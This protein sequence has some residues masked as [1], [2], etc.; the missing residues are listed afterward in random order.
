[1]SVVGT[2]I[3]FNETNEN[4]KLTSFNHPLHRLNRGSFD[5]AVN[6]L[7]A[8]SQ[9]SNENNPHHKNNLNRAVQNFVQQDGAFFVRNVK[10]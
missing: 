7:Q 10:P 5:K 6:D 3:P 2:R 9:Q 8:A 4:H 1:M